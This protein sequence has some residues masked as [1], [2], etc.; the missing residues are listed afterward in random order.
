MIVR[1]NIYQKA[2]G[3]AIYWSEEVVKNLRSRVKLAKEVG[4]DNAEC[5][6]LWIKILPNGSLLKNPRIQ[7]EH[8]AIEQLQESISYDLKF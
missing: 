7:V 3:Y 4:Y 2:R 5:E 6:F 8:T 1:P